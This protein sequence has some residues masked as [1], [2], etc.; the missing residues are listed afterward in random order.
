MLPVG[1]VAAAR[2]I[3]GFTLIELIIVIVL[4][5]ILA[6][7]SVQFISRSVQGA[8]DSANRQQLAATAAVIHEQIAAALRQ[9]LPGSVRVS[10]D[11]RCVEYIPVLAGSVYAALDTS[12]AITELAVLPASATNSI[13][14]YLV[15]YP[16][17]GNVYA[18][19][20]PGPVTLQPVTL[21]AGTAEQTLTLIDAHRFPLAS[22]TRRFFIADN[23]QAMCQDGQWLYR[24]RNYGFVADINDLQAALPVTQASGRD[25]IAWPLQDHSAEFRI[26]PPTLQRNALVAYRL[27]LQNP[28]S[29]DM[30]TLAQ[31]VQIRN[32]P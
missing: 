11:G 2:N 19:Q 1:A 9:A 8:L 26:Q 3:R 13:S 17:A 31:E 21:A 24:Y 6:V 15:I 10:A 29:T 25:V 20:N 4:S 14:G 27:T 23:P 18:R 7:V 28:G 16:L 22:P 5:S 30:L 32:V 12:Q